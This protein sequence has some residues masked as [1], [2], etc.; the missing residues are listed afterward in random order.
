M[1]LGFP[2]EEKKRKAETNDAP[3]MASV[4]ILEPGVDAALVVAG[5][6]AHQRAMGGD[7]LHACGSNRQTQHQVNP[8]HPLRTMGKS[9]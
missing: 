9:V 8:D 1:S 5:V 6:P 2:E 4:A 7:L 3:C